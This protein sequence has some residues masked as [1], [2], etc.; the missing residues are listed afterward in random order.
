MNIF[1]IEIGRISRRGNFEKFC[2]KVVS[3]PDSCYV[4]DVRR[5]FEMKYEG[6]DVR[7][8]QA[9]EVAELSEPT[10]MGRKQES[11]HEKEFYLHFRVEYTEKEKELHKEYRT[12]QIKADEARQSLH[13]SIEERYKKLYYSGICGRH[14]MDLRSDSYGTYCDKFPIN[15]V[16]FEA[17]AQK[18]EEGFVPD[19][20]PEP[21]P[22]P[23]EGFDPGTTPAPEPEPTPIPVEG[24]IA[25][26]R[27]FPDVPF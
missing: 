4:S 13:S 15:G 3:V 16:L 17:T 22:T 8:S 23:E 5:H 26:G 19:P 7:T 9:E 10:V 6:F 11:P 14:S 21:E 24:I 20:V 12:N 1:L 2:Q 27:E 18:A 25:E